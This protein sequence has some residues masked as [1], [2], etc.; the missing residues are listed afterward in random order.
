MKI[1]R[2][3]LT[4]M[5]FLFLL[6][7]PFFS[8][9]STHSDSNQTR[10]KLSTGITYAA[11]NLFI[12]TYNNSGSSGDIAIQDYP[13]QIQKQFPIHC[14]IASLTLECPFNRFFQMDFRL[15]KNTPPLS[16]K[17]TIKEWGI[18]YSS[19]YP[20]ANFYT[21]DRTST[22][23]YTLDYWKASLFGE[24]RFLQYIF[25]DI[26]GKIGIDY[27]RYQYTL[28]QLDQ[29]Y[30]SYSNYIDFLPAGT[31]QHTSTSGVSLDFLGQY[32]SLV[33]GPCLEIRLDQFSIYIDSLMYLGLLYTSDTDF[34][35]K[36]YYTST[37]LLVGF[38]GSVR[39][40]WQLS[41]LWAASFQLETEAHLNGGGSTSQ[42]VDLNTGESIW[43]QLYTGNY[44]NVTQAGFI[45]AYSL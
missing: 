5:G 19:G 17:A 7:T 20:W 39:L 45:L 31:N 40:T 9:G 1:N 23:E 43:N 21:L 33:F 10:L 34:I 29:E 13:Y 6:S 11:G 32:V 30:T 8:F 16:D 15:D 35:S 14:P 2:L 25:P 4:L 41:E 28:Y 38:S 36:Q 42:I 3:P 27:R 44:L 18:W 26:S 37:S 12:L 22:C 24:I